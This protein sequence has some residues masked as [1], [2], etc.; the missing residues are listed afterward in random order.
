MDDESMTWGYKSM[1]EGPTNMLGV[2]ITLL[3]TKTMPNNHHYSTI[4]RH[5]TTT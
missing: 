2:F 5:I 1:V 4:M 3:H